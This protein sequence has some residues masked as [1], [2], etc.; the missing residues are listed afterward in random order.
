V[1][2]PGNTSCIPWDPAYYDINNLYALVADNPN[3]GAEVN[4]MNNDLKV[5]YSDQFSLGMRNLVEVAGTEWNTSVTLSHIRG[6]DGILFT[7]GNR[8]EDGSF[9]PPGQTFGGAPFGFPIPG[10]GTL[11]IADNAIE[12]RLN[13]VLLSVDKPFTSE[14]GWGATFAYTYQDAE[15]NRGEAASAD[16]HY[17]FDLPNLNGASFIDSIGIPRHRL[18]ATGVTEVAGFTLSGKLTLE[19][20]TA[21]QYFDFTDP[22]NGFR[23]AYYS[24]ESIEYKQVDIAIQKDW[25]TGTSFRPYVRADIFNVFDWENWNDYN[26]DGQQVGLNIRGPTRYFKL[27][28]GFD[29]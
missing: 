9:F 14:S 20:P 3:L 28:L 7:L 21:R 26:V 6:Y 27:S 8:R 13:S 16:E 15:E 29:W 10:Y 5:P 4:L 23:G 18:V 25:D 17:L 19:S 24:D 1:C 22:M 11:I 2:E 12:T